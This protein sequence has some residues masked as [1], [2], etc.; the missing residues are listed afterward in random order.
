MDFINALIGFVRG[1]MAAPAF[2][3][4]HWRR[5]KIAIE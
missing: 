2:S 5:G 4:A 1:E 3:V